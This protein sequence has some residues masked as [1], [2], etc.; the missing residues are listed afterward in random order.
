MKDEDGRRRTADRGDARG[1]QAMCA[2]IS[3]YIGWLV[4]SRGFSSPASSLSYADL[5]AAAHLS[6]IDYLGDVP[7]SE[8]DATPKAGMRA[9]NPV[10]RSGR[11]WPSGWPERPASAH[12]RRTSI[13]ERP[14]ARWRMMGYAAPRTISR[15]DGCRLRRRR[16]SRAA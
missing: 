2:I 13:S 11:F 15:Q 5:A 14:H 4:G 16:L 12:L 1:A 8:N 6:A 7:W 3:A 9:S 10:P